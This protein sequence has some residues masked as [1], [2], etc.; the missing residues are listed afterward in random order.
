MK[1]TVNWQD[2]QA[3]V[4]KTE[5]NVRNIKVKDKKVILILA[6]E[7]DDGLTATFDIE[8]IISITPEQ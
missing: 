7:N 5:Y 6:G 1:V 3:F 8:D 4:Y 2:N